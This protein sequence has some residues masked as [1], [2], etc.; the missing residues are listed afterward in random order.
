MLFNPLCRMLQATRQPVDLLSLL[1]HGSPEIAGKRL[2]I[3]CQ[4]GHQ[5]RLLR[6]GHFRC[7]GR[8]R[9]SPVSGEIGNG[10][11]RF[12][13]D[14]ADDRD[15]TGA[16]G[17]GDGFVIERPQILDAASAAAENKR[18]A[19]ASLAGAPDC[20]RDL[21]RR[22]FALNLRGVDDDSDVRR[23]AFERG[24]Y[25]T[26]C[27]C[28]GG[29]D[30]ADFAR[31]AWQGTFGGIVEE[32]LAFELVLEAKELLV[33]IA[34]ACLAC[35][36]DVQLKVTACFVQRDEDAGFNVLA[37]CQAP[38]E[39]LGAVPEHHA[40]DLRASVLEREVDVPGGGERQVG[41]FSGDPAQRERGF[42]PFSRQSIEHGY[43]DD[44]RLKKRFG[45]LNSGHARILHACQLMHTL[46]A[47]GVLLGAP[48]GW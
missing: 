46:R 21:F 25:I 36:F 26:Q 33:E 15:G 14:A 35:R 31:K 29:G 32:S 30:D 7:C 4:G 18:V 37:V 20:A 6:C 16:D 45:S 38:A 27:G 24:Q 42:E 3:R 41:D 9:C 11:V 28:L 22:T 23:A 48:S 17:S 5:R 47:P 13:T 44:R 10:E 34:D 2:P 8:R 12:V 43:G 1:F 40:A 19:L 39:Q